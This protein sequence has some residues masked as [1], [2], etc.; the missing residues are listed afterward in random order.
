MDKILLFAGTT[1]GRNLAEFLE[2]NQIPTEVCVATQ[3]GETLLEEGKYL[4]VH[5]G[6]LD[7]TEMEQQIQKQQITLVID[8]THPYAVIVSQNI[9]RACSRTG[10]EYIRLARK[11]TDASWKQEMEDVTEVASVAEAA[12]FLAKKEGRIFAAT[13]SKE[14]SA[15]QVIP[16]YQ[17]RVVARVLSTPEAVSECAMLGFSGKNLIC[18]QGPFTEDL[19]VAMLR[20]AQASWMVTKES[21]KAGGFLE[22]LRAAKKAG[23]KLVVIKRP[24]ER[25]EE[26]AEDQKEENLYAI[27]D[28]GQIRSL[29]GK[30][31]GICPKRQLYLV[32]IGMGNEKNRTVEAEQ[33]CQSADLLIGARRMLQS[34]KTEG[35]VVFESYKPDE[36]AAY[37]AEHPQYE[38]AAVLL[39]GD[40]GFYS[41]AKKL[42]DAI[43]RTEGLEQME[44]YPVSGISS[45]VY[46]CGKLGVSWENVHLLSLHGRKQNLI[47]AVK[48]HEK[49]FVLCGEK[50]GI[51]KICCK[52]KEYGLGDVKVAVGTDLSYEQERIVQGTAES[53]MKEDFA[54]LSVLLICNPDVKK[55]IGHGLDDDLFLRG[56]V[57]MTKSEV[58]SISLSK[59]RLHKDAVVWD[60]GA[61]TGSVSIEAA[62]LAKDG[63]VY[64]IEKKDEAIDLLEQNKRKFGTDNLEII[65]GLAP[66]ALEGLPAPTHAFIGGSSGNLKEILEVLLEQNPRVRVVINAIALETVAEAMQCLKSM[67]FT[68][69]DIAQVSVAKGKKL[70]SYEMMMGQN[71]VYIFSCTGGETA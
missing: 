21:G 5:A 54:P 22:K 8:A 42:Y 53:L 31:L 47:D 37:L 32:G 15:Y 65:K 46:F 64:A 50:D 27:C 2:K 45:V 30:R 29:L 41:G 40:I 3:Y 67:A 35:K 66:E 55:R 36:I 56:K 24:G 10:T 51:S 63:V 34:V 23:A 9:R 70:G 19:N 16:D 71:P 7:E 28:E 59:L 13:G 68:D 69:V 18:M 52:L 33:I 4:H 57:P 60:V 62:S 39:S 6:R 58:R 43:E 11:E 25:S 61:G 26:I 12:A 14:L 44:I 20:Q 1:E 49:V 17:D 38:T 48:Y